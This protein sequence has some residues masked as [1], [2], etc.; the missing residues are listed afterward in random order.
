MKK[1]ITTVV[2]SIASIL[3]FSQTI[4]TIITTP[5]YKSYFSYQTHT[6]LFVSYL[7]YKGGGDCSRKKMR[8]TTNGL[9][10]SAKAKDYK[11]SG[12]DIGH[13]A[14]AEDFANNCEKEK[15]TFYFYNALPQKP[16]LNR[17]CWSKIEAQVREESQTDSLLIICGGFQFNSKIGKTSVPA[18][19]FKIVKN[20]STRTVKCYLFPNNDSNTFEEIA[21]SQLLQKISFGNILD[22]EY[23]LQ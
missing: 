16:K 7:L 22:K 2:L 11:N 18:S 3:A 5:I 4:D 8:F 19:C 20:I 9:K 14:N 17:G 15:L 1:I 13:L 23:K 21:L 12:Y 6:P 10:Q